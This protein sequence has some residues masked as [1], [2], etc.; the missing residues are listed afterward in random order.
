MGTRVVVLLY[1]LLYWSFIALYA[2]ALYIKFYAP[3]H[4]FSNHYLADLICMPI[5]F[6]LVGEIFRIFKINA[7]LSL[8]K[9]IFGVAYFSFLF[10]FLLPQFSN[11]Y[12]R[13]WCDV[14][15]YCLGGGIY[16]LSIKILKPHV[17]N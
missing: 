4:D 7:S 1:H 5:V 6:Y 16:F 8:P 17:V 14:V 10:E 9:I 15:M 13:D 12:T 3:N 2:W 11:R